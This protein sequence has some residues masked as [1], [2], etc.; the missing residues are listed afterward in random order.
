VPILRRCPGVG[1]QRCGVLC[2]G[3]RCPAHAQVHERDRTRSKRARR[4]YSYAEQ[5]RRAAV[6]AAWLAE[7][8]AWCPGWGRPG[9]QVQA[10]ELTAEH[11]DAVARGGA[12]GQP[13][14]VLCR[15]CNSVKGDRDQG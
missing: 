6:V 15:S 4:P 2:E 11:P 5:Q 9:H 14:T 12:E 8:G 3:T 13:L 7:Y 1:G 10:G